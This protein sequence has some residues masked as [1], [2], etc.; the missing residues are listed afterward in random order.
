MIEGDDKGI[1]DFLVNAGFRGP[2]TRDIAVDDPDGVY[3]FLPIDPE[4]RAAGRIQLVVI[5]FAAEPKAYA[6]RLGGIFRVRESKPLPPPSPDFE[7]D[8]RYKRG[9]L[10]IILEPESEPQGTLQ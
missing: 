9:F 3:F 4:N 7:N 8:E 10:S 2:S 6:D 5:G 1:I